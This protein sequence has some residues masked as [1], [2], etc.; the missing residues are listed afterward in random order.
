MDGEGGADVQP[1]GHG[2]LAAV[3]ADDVLDDREA[4][5]GTAGG[6]GARRVGPVEPLED[7]VQVFAADADALVRHGDFDTV[8]T[9]TDTDCDAGVRAAVGDRV[10]EQVAECGDELGVAA[11]RTQFALTAAVEDDALAV[12]GRA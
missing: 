6:A 1:A 11:Q 4:E 5:A 9:M 10:L 7:A 8:P 2:D 3:V 12:G